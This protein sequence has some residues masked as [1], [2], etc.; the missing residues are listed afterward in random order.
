MSVLAATADGYHVFTSAGDHHVALEGH[1]VGALHPGPAGSWIAIVDRTGIWQHRADGTWA[2][3]ASGDH[4]LTS[5]TTLGDTVFAGAVG[6]RVLRAEAG[7]ALV[8]LPGFDAAPGRDE[9]HAVGSDLEVRSFSATAGGALLANVHVGG[10]LRSDDS[11]ATW[12]PTIAVDA[13]VHEVRAHPTDE[14]LVVAAAAVGL[15]ISR[16]GGE[17]WDV[18]TEG[19]HAT[20]ARAIAFVGGDVLFSI[21]EG[22]FARRGTI[23][24]RAVGSGPVEPVRD[25][26]PEWLEGNIDTRCLGSGRGR[27][28]LA[29]AAGDIWASAQG[30]RGWERIASGLPRV[31]SVAVV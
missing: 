14:N 12:A 15:C 30:S 6:P 25:G 20:Y 17:R 26:L 13:D 3:F 9:W 27:A 16:D 10:I 18:V 1:R 2:P 22:P 5:L 24:R 7:G 29:D 11:G 21:S 31:Q 23:Y 8:P 28:A 19:L 4:E